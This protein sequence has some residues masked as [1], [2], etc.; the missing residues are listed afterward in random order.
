MPSVPEI[1]LHFD[2]LDAV[3]C[4]NRLMF[5]LSLFARRTLLVV[6]FGRCRR[7]LSTMAGPIVSTTWLKDELDKADANSTLIVFDTT[8]IP[9]RNG[10]DYYLK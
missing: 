7:R 6:Q 4:Q 10:Y 1:A 5:R 9:F 3:Y 8:W 2:P